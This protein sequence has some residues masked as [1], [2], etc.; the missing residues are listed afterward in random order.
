VCFAEEL[1]RTMTEEE[2]TAK[3]SELTNI[4]LDKYNKHIQE[5]NTEQEE[6]VMTGGKITFFKLL[7]IN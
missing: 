4:A 7:G 2:R 3:F 5:T 1:M 6:E